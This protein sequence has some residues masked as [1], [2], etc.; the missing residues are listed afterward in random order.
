[1]FSALLDRAT[2]SIP[3]TLAACI[4]MM[5]P[6][7]ALAVWGF[8]L[9][10]FGAGALYFVVWWTMLFS[11]LPFRAAPDGTEVVVPGQD[12]GAPH[13]PQMRRKAVWTTLV[14]D[15]VFLVAVAAFP[16]AGL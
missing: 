8:R 16:L 14:A 6:M 2:T 11:V 15:V 1:M 12:L 3:R 4:L 7:L 5:L 10:G 13:R 9:S